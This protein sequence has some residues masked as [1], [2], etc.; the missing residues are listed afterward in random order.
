MLTQTPTADWLAAHRRVWEK[1]RVLRQVYTQ[2]FGLLRGACAP[3][4]PLVEIGCGPAFFKRVYPEIVATDTRMN[5]YA[6]CIVDAHELPFGEAAVGNLV[7]LDVFHHLVD[8]QRFLSEAAH[9]LRRG[10]R[11]VMLEPWLGLA[12]RWFYRCVHHE[13]CD[14]QVDPARP[15]DSGAKDPMQGNAALPYLYFRP[16]GYLDRLSLPLAVVERRP[17]AA[18]PW[19]LSGGF[20]PFSLLP[21]ALASAADAVDRFLTRAPALTASRCLVVIERVADRH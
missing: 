13:E 3:G 19:L 4:S 10:G 14:L 20:Q 15:W 21:P 16:G 5:A 8:P 9:V 6:D 7:M 1:K 12:G 17:F 18:L 2:W 11:I